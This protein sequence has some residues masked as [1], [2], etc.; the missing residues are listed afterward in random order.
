M[1]EIFSRR[2]VYSVMDAIKWC[3]ELDASLVENEH[4]LLGL[5]E[6]ASFAKILF[7]RK[8]ITLEVLCSELQSQRNGVAQPSELP[9][10][11]F[12]E[13]I[14]ETFLSANNFRK[15]VRSSELASIH[16]VFGLFETANPETVSGKI[17]EQLGMDR[18]EVVAN[19]EQ[20]SKNAAQLYKREYCQDRWT[21][22][23]EKERIATLSKR[24]QLPSDLGHYFNN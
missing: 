21:V 23:E 11:M 12:S 3:I 15:R 18:K 22:A 19:I 2:A 9:Q 6:N 8:N 17:L 20:I 16:L 7:N 1:F 13:N 14:R 24:F 4:L 10:L 5:V